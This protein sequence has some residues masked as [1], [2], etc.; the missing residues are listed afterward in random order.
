MKRDPIGIEGKEDGML[1]VIE[2]IIVRH[3]LSEK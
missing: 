2:R 1:S 3:V